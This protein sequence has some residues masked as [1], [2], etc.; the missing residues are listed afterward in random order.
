[1]ID[2]P[3]ALPNVVNACFLAFGALALVLLL[4]ETHITLRHRRDYGLIVSR[5]CARHIFR[6]KREEKY[7]AIVD[8]RTLPDDIESAA[9]KE[10]LPLIRQRLP[11]RR[12]FT[13]NVL[14]TLVC[15][16]LLAMV[17]C[18]YIKVTF[19]SSANSCTT[20][21]DNLLACR[22]IQQSLVRLPL[23][24]SLR[25]RKQPQHRSRR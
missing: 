24:S 15:H 3:Y 1:M 14:F 20:D 18:G 25:S 8:L 4:E 9:R 23:Y 16:G 22:D 17:S 10:S 5:W 13:S 19:D 7:E 21:A 12:V 6:I 2:Y 11:F